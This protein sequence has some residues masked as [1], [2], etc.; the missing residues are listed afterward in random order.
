DRHVAEVVR[1]R[2]APRLVGEGW[3]GQSG[4]SMHDVEGRHK[5]P[6]ILTPNSHFAG[7]PA[8]AGGRLSASAAPAACEPPPRRNS[9][10]TAASADL[11]STAL[12]RMQPLRLGPALFGCSHGFKCEIIQASFSG[13]GLVPKRAVSSEKTKGSVPRALS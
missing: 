12:T 9:N 5:L 1:L 7:I 3:R 2:W 6:T 11:R 13:T 10:N 4:A 8:L